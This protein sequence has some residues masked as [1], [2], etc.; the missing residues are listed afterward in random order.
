MPRLRASSSAMP[1]SAAY[2]RTSSVIFIEQKCGPHMEHPPLPR[3]R[4]DRKMRGLGRSS[5]FAIN[6]CS[7]VLEFCSLLLHSVFDRCALI[8]RMF[9][10]VLPH[11]LGDVDERRQPANLALRVTFD[12][13]YPAA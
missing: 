4:R 11:I 9:G 13:I 1:C 10:G 5:W 6:F 12:I 2:F 7:A 8:N 3:L